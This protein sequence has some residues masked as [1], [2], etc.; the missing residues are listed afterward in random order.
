MRV[1]ILLSGHIRT[2]KECTSSTGWMKGFDLFG[3]TYTSKYGYH[4]FI[5]SQVQVKEEEVDPEE[6]LSEIPFIN[7]TY[8]EDQRDLHIEEHF[9]YTMCNFYHGYYQYKCI[10]DGL[11]LIEEHEKK[12]GLKYDIIVRT[13]FDLQ[14]NPEFKLPL[15]PYRFCIDRR[16]TFPNDHFIAGSRDEMM[17]LPKYIHS[18]YFSPRQ[19]SALRPPHGMLEEF[20]QGKDV[21]LL[22]IG[23]VRRP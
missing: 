3:S 12:T 21:R 6:E 23:S 16:N 11:N 8:T 17:K 5:Q 18:Q 20:L 9:D 14:Y 1:A 22:D 2:W 13:R 7:L 4:P 15:D 10:Q 19:K